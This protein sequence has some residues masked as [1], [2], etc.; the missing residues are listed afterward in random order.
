M[1]SET[2]E[3]EDN[4]ERWYLNSQGK[5]FSI[6]KAPTED[7]L[8]IADLFRRDA[9]TNQ[10]KLFLISSNS[11]PTLVHHYHKSVSKPTSNTDP[12]YILA[13]YF[14]IF[15]KGKNRKWSDYTGLNVDYTDYSD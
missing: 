1:S 9:K 11:W 13:K 3:K 4:L 2:A 12:A 14:R 8:A 6:S 10:P 7:L 15:D 5:K